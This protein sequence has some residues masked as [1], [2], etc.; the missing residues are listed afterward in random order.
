METNETD[1]KLKNYNPKLR[2]IILPLC[3][4]S[5]LSF[6]MNFDF[7]GI[8][9]LQL[10]EYFKLNSVEFQLIYS[11]S[12]I[13]NIVFP[14]FSGSFIDHIGYS[15]SMI[16][17]TCILLIAQTICVHSIINTNYMELLIGR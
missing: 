4:F 10:I 9:S 14:I 8:L 13:P 16:L 6:Y 17:F 1:T 15:K 2:W 5:G 11:V 12:I 3:C 7:P